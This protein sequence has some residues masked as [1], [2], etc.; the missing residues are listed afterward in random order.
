MK[1]DVAQL[2]QLNELDFEQ[3]ATWPHEVKWVV[4]IVTALFS[5]GLGWF[6]LVSPKLPLLDSA[7][8]EEATLKS[9][10]QAK[11]RTAVNLSS[12]QEQLK[13]MQ[14]DFAFMLKS[15]PTSNETPGLLDDITYVGTTSGL[16]FRLLQWQPEIEKEFYTELPIQLEVTGKYHDFGQFVTKIATLPRI[17]TLHDF[18]LTNETEGLR[19]QMQ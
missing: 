4:A 14:Q 5:L 18:A 16:T 2:K 7:S 1:F 11:Y 17:V 13:Q 15:L 6:L 12:Y 8:A 19:L 9:Q 10:Y 3:V